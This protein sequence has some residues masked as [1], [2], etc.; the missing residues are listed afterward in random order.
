MVLKEIVNLKYSSSKLLV[1]EVVNI[2]LKDS[3]L[4]DDFT[5]NLED[6]NSVSISGLNHYY[7]NK[8]LVSLPYVRESHILNL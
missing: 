7:I 5:L 6:S 2:F 1:G 4:D 8:K 3:F